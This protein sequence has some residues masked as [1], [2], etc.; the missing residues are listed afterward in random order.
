MKIQNGIFYLINNFLISDFHSMFPEKAIE[1]IVEANVH[2][3]FLVFINKN[4]DFLI[5]YLI[6]EEAINTSYIMMK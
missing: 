5:I 6:L 2:C 1:V 3:I 4:I